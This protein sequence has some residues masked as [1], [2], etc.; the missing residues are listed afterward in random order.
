MGEVRRRKK[1]GQPSDES[2]LV[3]GHWCDEAGRRTVENCY[4]CC[5]SRRMMPAAPAEVGPEDVSGPGDESGSGD[6][7]GPG[8]ETV[9]EED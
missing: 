3:R 9:T 6:E 8:D 5:C 1:R 4:Y 2:W 7:S